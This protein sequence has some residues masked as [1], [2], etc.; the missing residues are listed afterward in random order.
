MS[1]GYRNVDYMPNRELSDG[2]SL[3]YNLWVTSWVEFWSSK[4]YSVWG[5]ADVV[6]FA[7]TTFCLLLIV[8]CILIY[9][10]TFENKSIRLLFKSTFY[11]I[12]GS[13]PRLFGRTSTWKSKN[14]GFTWSNTEWGAW[15]C[16]GDT[17]YYCFIIKIYWD[18][19][20]I[21]LI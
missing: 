2:K 19:N 1:A 8:S 3:D 4:T 15:S 7:W 18:I 9:F 21:S 17:H 20:M 14:P 13:I 6:L 12:T 10:L 5:V 16:L 11:P